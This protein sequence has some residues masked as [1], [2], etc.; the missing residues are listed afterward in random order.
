[1]VEVVDASVQRAAALIRQLLAFGSR[2]RI[3]SVDI[4]LNRMVRDMAKLFARTLH[5]RI[6]V[7]IRSS[8]DPVWARNLNSVYR[9]AMGLADK[10]SLA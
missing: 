5:R 1:M 4:D 9:L 3:S 8:D 6:S 10:S 2:D 7:D